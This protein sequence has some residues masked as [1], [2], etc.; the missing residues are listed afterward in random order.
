MDDEKGVGGMEMNWFYQGGGP[1]GGVEGYF[2]RIM[3]EFLLKLMISTSSQ[4]LCF[5]GIDS[6]SKDHNSI[7]LTSNWLISFCYQE[8]HQ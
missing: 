4:L 2:C 5:P 1:V 6:D 7:K 8:F 3:K